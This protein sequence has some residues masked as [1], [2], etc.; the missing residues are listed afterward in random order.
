MAPNATVV[1]DAPAA[2]K[3]PQSAQA[4]PCTIVIF[5][6]SGDLVQRKLIPALYGLA[7]D[8]SLARK[9]A[10]VG[11]ARTAMS[12]EAFQAKAVEATKGSADSGKVEEDTLKTF[13]QS[14]SYVSGDYDKA[15]GFEKL[16][17]RLD[18]IEKQSESG[19]N[20]L[21]YLATPPEVYP[22]IIEQL[23]KAGLA[24]PKNDKSWVRIIIEKP[25][26][27]DLQSAMKL[28]QTVLSVF[29]EPQVYRID[30]YLGK[31]TVQ[32]LLVL[33]FGN[34]IFEPLWNRNF[35]DHVQITASEALGV[36]QRASFYENTGAVRDM[37][38]SHMLQLTALVALEPPAVFD[39]TAVRNEKIKVLQSV[40]GFTAESVASDVVRG[41]YGPGS[42]KDGPAAGYRQEKGVKPESE[43][44]TFA[45][46]KLQIDNW[47]W[48]GV[49]FYLRTGKRLKRRMTEIV[50]EFRH[51]PHPLFR[52]QDVDSNRLVLNIQPEEGISISFGAKL[53][54]Q[55]MRVQSVAMDFSYHKAFGGAE[56]SAYAT[57]LN[58]CMRGDATLFDR[59]DSVEATWALVDPILEAWRGKKPA[60]P[61]YAAGSWGPAESD[62]LLE[63]NGRSWRNSE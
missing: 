61:N 24:K 12:D 62:A 49:P 45:A 3:S 30:H 8:K 25:F 55:E 6:A 50:I 47:R 41:Q 56:R 22:L 28:N 36:E 32:N 53:P 40:R 14:F 44:E 17:K 60:F 63:R 52:G 5:G 43:T 51:A 35:V 13:A 10:I 59:A 19:G 21:Y 18:E 46:I 27:R 57:L 29:D 37:I 20:R 54:G 2:K 39:A 4:D 31:D 42:G 38:Q 26:G 58:D 9:F 15:E 16:S 33:R 11:F 7:A 34:G 1:A 23:K 48:A